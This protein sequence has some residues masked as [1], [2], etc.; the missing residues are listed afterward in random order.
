MSEPARRTYFWDFFGPRAKPTAEHFKR[1]LQGFLDQHGVGEQALIEVS[2]QPA[3]HGI[4]VV[5][6]EPHWPLIE[7]ALRPRRFEVTAPGA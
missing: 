6:P 4:G 3:H 2:L 7:K 1:H 5:T